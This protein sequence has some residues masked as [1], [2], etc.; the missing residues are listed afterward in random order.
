MEDYENI[1]PVSCVFELKTYLIYKIN[2]AEN[3][4]N[5]KSDKENHF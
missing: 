4:I 1:E 5:N 2:F 3:I